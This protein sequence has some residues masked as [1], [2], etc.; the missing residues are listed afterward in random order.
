MSKGGA[1]GD[2]IGRK[3]ICNALM[4]N[5]DLAQVRAGKYI[6]NGL[7]TAG[8]D[9]AGVTRFLRAD[10]RPY[11]AADVVATLLGPCSQDAASNN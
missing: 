5:I 10:R 1:A 7:V 3:C 6:E 9:L 11:T 8:D 2:T 4:A